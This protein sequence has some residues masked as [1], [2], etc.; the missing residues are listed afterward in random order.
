MIKPMDR[1]NLA[2]FVNFEWVCCCYFG[3]LWIRA[4]RK[5]SKNDCS[6]QTRINIQISSLQWNPN[7]KWIWIGMYFSLLNEMD[8]ISEK[9]HIAWH[10]QTMFVYCK[11]QLHAAME[12]TQWM[13]VTKIKSA[14]DE[15]SYLSLGMH[16]ICN[17]F[18]DFWCESRSCLIVCLW[19][20]ACVYACPIAHIDRLRFYS[21]SFPSSFFFIACVC[22]RRSFN[23]MILDWKIL[24][25]LWVRGNET[26]VWYEDDA[27]DDKCKKV[28]LNW[29]TCEFGW[30]RLI[31]TGG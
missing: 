19:V 17:L 25:K 16:T 11:V 2:R 23:W 14:A 3:G 4:Q 1:Q 13:N 30:H 5:K 26:Y 22:C 29:V 12:Q 15:W 27:M 6:S 21:F 24:H 31:S 28:K 7:S 10:H 20:C 18:V 9:K 8:N